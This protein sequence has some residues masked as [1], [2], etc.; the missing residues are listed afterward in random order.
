[1]NKNISDIR[2][3]YQL[4]S[5]LETDIA[6]DPF[7]QFN[8]WWDDAV[9]SELDEVNAMTLATA[10]LAGLPDARIVL[11]KSFTDAG[12]VFL[13]TTAVKRV[14]SSPKTHGPVWFFSGKNWKGR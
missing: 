11:L 8:H 5:L 7:T 13:Q 4:Q 14:K 10:S 9:K 12:F 3:D 2:K 6:A 1:M